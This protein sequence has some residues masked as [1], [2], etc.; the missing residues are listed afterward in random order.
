M[1]L[2]KGLPRDT[3]LNVNVPNLPADRLA[4]I[5]FTRQ[6]HRVYENAI[7]ETFDPWGRK[8]YWIG[9]GTPAWDR[10]PDTDSTA[11]LLDHCISVT[12]IHLDLTSH[13]AL[14]SMKKNWR[15]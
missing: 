5:R 6:G 15:F 7:K 14:A 9:G 2:E 13:E 3:L 11:V 12:P 10:D 8:H 4:G 1:V